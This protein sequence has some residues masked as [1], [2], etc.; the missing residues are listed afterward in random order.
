MQNRHGYLFFFLLAPQ[1]AA[2]AIP[3]RLSTRESVGC[4]EPPVRESGR[5]DCH[6]NTSFDALRR[7]TGRFG[8]C[9]KENVK[10]MFAVTVKKRKKIFRYY[11]D[12]L[13][14]MG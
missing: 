14:L 7:N 11:I 5:S 6:Y 3:E 10:Y 9:T 12:I 4:T 1:S 13:T 2:A 8:C